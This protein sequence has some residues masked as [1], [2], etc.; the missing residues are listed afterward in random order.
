MRIREIM[1]KP[2]VTCPADANLDA[3]AS[4]MWEYDCGIVPIVDHDGRLAGVVTD[5]DIAISA[6]TKGLPL[7]M[8]PVTTAMA[9]NVL[10]C[11]AD[12]N[13]ES[14]ERLMRQ[15]QI[16][17][18]PVLDTEGHPIGI[19][20]LNDLARIAAKVHRSSVEHEVVETLAAIG[21]PHATARSSRAEFVL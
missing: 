21:Q 6:Y 11:H 16:R 2:V 9:A 5:R 7:A 14:A 18:V 13:I 4:L 12:D 20:S 17:R 8:I 3:A 10:A 15:S 19:L 1:S